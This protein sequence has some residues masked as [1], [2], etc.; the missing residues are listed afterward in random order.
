[1]TT[2]ISPSDS[3][4]FKALLTLVSSTSSTLKTIS[5]TSSDT[6]YSFSLSKSLNDQ[7]MDFPFLKR[8]ISSYSEPSTTRLIPQPR[9][10]FWI[11]S[12]FNDS[13]TNCK[14]FQTTVW[15]SF[16]RAWNGLFQYTSDAWINP[17]HP[18]GITFFIC[19]PFSYLDKSVEIFYAY[20]LNFC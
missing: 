1:M 20:L 16:K 14:W 2:T 15:Y 19:T 12:T 17:V 6:V 5:A 10:V 9:N 13:Q 7:R 18:S 3:P 8:D 11:S 4:P